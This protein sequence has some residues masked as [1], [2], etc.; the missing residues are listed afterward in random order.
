MNSETTRK[1]GLRSILLVLALLSILALL[2]W[3]LPRLA[4]H[5]LAEP[6][7][8]VEVLTAAPCDLNQ[9]SCSASNGRVSVSF[10][11]TPVPIRSLQTLTADL[12]LDGLQADRIQLSLE[13][14]D[15]Y[16]GLNQIALT[17]GALP[18]QWL[19]STELAVCTTGRMIWRARLIIEGQGQRLTTWFDF[20]A[21]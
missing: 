15:M 7:Q 8:D 20:A 17:P 6:A 21:R 10:G 12:R 2:I 18:G 5:W 4:E 13:G 11:L 9:S 3:Q 16:M 1:E 19:G 14:R